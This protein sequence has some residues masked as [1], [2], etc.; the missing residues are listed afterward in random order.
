MLLV[1]VNLVNLV[2]V[3]E[4]EEYVLPLVEVFRPSEKTL[5]VNVP[6]LGV[7]VVVVL[8]F[9]VRVVVLLLLD[10]G[11]RLTVDL[12]EVGDLRDVEEVLY[13]VELGP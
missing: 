11:L 9:S 8:P 1:L 6:D 13:D 10:L 5:S 2:D 3:G 4:D 12:L 7:V